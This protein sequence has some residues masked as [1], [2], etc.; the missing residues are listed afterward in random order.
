MSIPLLVVLASQAIA[1]ESAVE[2]VA[3]RYTDVKAITAE[4]TQITHNPLYGD[5][6]QTGSLAL[7]RPS[8]I[9]W[10]SSGDGRLFVSDGDTMWM[11]T[12]ADNQVIRT[13]GFKP[14]P[15]SAMSLLHSLDRLEQLFVVT[16]VEGEGRILDMRPRADE[17]VDRVRLELD[18]ALMLRRLVITDP[19]GSTTELR[20]S[21]VALDPELKP[22]VFS[23]TIP[24]G[25]EVIDAGGL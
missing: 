2:A 6:T 19:L 3:K 17:S 25:A 8:R 22:T 21:K 13:G 1:G 7:Q 15:S 14:S 12:P 11:Y 24:D 20:F 4:F 18:D 5:D 23:F 9:R 16:E 10:E